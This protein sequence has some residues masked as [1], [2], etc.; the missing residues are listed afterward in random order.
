MALI[1]IDTEESIA[2]FECDEVF[3][4]MVKTYIW[5]NHKKNKFQKVN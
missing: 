3:A 2:K 1:I 4:K 5:D